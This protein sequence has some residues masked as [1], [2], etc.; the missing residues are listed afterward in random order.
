MP[1]GDAKRD[2]FGPLAM[3]SLAPPR[4]DLAACGALAATSA[5]L[6][7]VGRRRRSDAG[8]HAAG[9]RPAAR[10]TRRARRPALADRPAC[11]EARGRKRAGVRLC[12]PDNPGRRHAAAVSFD[13]TGKAQR[14]D[15]V[16]HDRRIRRRAARQPGSR[17]AIRRGGRR[18]ADH[19]DPQSRIPNRDVPACCTP[20]LYKKRASAR[21]PAATRR[22]IRMRWAKKLSCSTRTR[23][24][25][26]RSTRSPNE[27]SDGA[28]RRARA[29]WIGGASPAPADARRNGQAAPRGRRDDRAAGA[30]RLGRIAVRAP[31]PHM[32]LHRLD[33]LL[34]RER[35]G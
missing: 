26:R 6:A 15:D 21:R 25:W 23:S 11:V 34:Q 2:A 4:P 17:G 31:S 29:G 7:Q 18:S 5:G 30:R 33:Q 19:D 12:A 3:S 24:G 16:F 22:S 14:D 8:V 9:S 20:G 13:A 10:R 28:E 1:H 35:L 32:L 27:R